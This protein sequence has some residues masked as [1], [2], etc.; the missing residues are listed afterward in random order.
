M[1]RT[2]CDNG[3]FHFLRTCLPAM[4]LSNQCSQCCIDKEATKKT[5]TT[6]N[7]ETKGS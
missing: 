4:Y 3:K 7:E 2:N 6:D 1:S 5:K